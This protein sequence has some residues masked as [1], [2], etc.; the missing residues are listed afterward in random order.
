MSANRLQDNLEREGFLMYNSDIGDRH[1][2]KNLLSPLVLV[3][4]TVAS[5]KVG[6]VNF[7]FIHSSL[8]SNLKHLLDT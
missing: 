1:P 4:V 8:Q 2:K 3:A 5:N 7:N 6:D